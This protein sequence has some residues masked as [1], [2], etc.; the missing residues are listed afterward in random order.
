MT[1]FPTKGYIYGIQNKIPAEDIQTAA[2]YDSMNWLCVDGSI[3][4]VR[5]REQ[6]GSSGDVG[7]SYNEIFAPRKDGVT[8]HF[9]KINTKIQYYNT[10]TSDWVDVITG[11]TTGSIYTFSTYIS[12][13]GSYLYATGI[14]GLYKISVANPTSYKDMYDSAKNYKGYSILNEQ[15]MFLWNTPTDKTGIYLSKIDPQGTN[16]STVTNEVLGASGSTTYSGTLAQATGKR[17][18]FGVT[19]TGTLAAGVE[20]FTDNYSGTLTGSLGGTGT[21]NYATGAYTITFNNV[22]TSGNIEADYQY[23]DSNVNGITDFTFST[24]RL[25]GEGDII[26][27]EFRGEPI[28]NIVIY[29][30]KYYSFKKTC[31]YELDLTDD[32]TNATNNVY[33]V[34]IGI[35][36]LKSVIS[37]GKGMIYMDTSNPDVPMLSI[38]QRNPVGGNLEPVNLTPLFSWEQFNMDDCVLETWGQYVLIGTKDRNSTVN[39]RLVLVDLNQNYSPMVTNYSAYSITKN[40]GYLYTGDS[41]TETTYRVFSG[42]DDLGEQIDNFWIGKAEKYDSE[43]LKR[44]RY[45]RIKGLIDKNQS[46]AIYA[47]FDGDEYTQLGTILGTGDYV[48]NTDPQTIGSHMLGEVTVGGGQPL[49]AYPFYTS[50]R[51]RVPKFRTR[52]LKYIAD[53]IGYA[54]IQLETDFDILQFEQKIP[55]KFRIKEH[56]S[57]NGEQTDLPTFDH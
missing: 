8:V 11:L 19:I 44:F 38:L 3:E 47:S 2:A 49:V 53:G 6:I 17:F 36:S 13:A 31:V 32:D 20:T 26:S 52:Q 55:K 10:T 40:A 21:I 39:D 33:R 57:L 30:G 24:P 43:N 25:A 35:P 12:L 1:E 22:V 45:I 27:Q 41:L 14:D 5:G 18:V 9:R 4:L 28:Q 56:V 46:I 48:D 29:E 16:Y 51:C 42:F 54:S 15:R 37:V 7:A 23:E 50:I 34:D